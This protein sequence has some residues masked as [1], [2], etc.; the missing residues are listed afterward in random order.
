MTSGMPTF[1][2]EL[3]LIAFS[4]AVLAAVLAPLAVLLDGAAAGR[5]CALGGVCHRNP[6]CR[7]PTPDIR[8]PQEDLNLSGRWW[9]L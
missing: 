5:M 4:L 8:E 9:N 2:P 1:A 6:L 7:E 3:D